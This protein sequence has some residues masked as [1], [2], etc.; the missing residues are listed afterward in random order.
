MTF[1]SFWQILDA[2]G[3]IITATAE[4]ARYLKSQW[5]QRLGASTACTPAIRAWTQAQADWLQRT[6]RRPK[7]LSAHSVIRIWQQ[8]IHTHNP[9]LT[10][11]R[12]LAKLAV[13]TDRTL[14]EHQIDPT[15]SQRLQE[16]DEC[17]I[18][19][20][21]RYQQLLDDTHSLDAARTLEFLTTQSPNLPAATVGL[22]GFT[23]EHAQ[24]T[25][26]W[27]HCRQAG[28]QLIEL[29]PVKL[30]STASVCDVATEVDE[31]TALVNWLGQALDK[32]KV[33]MIQV[34][35]EQ[36]AQHQTAL[37]RLIGE[38]LLGKTPADT[39]WARAPVR[40]SD[41]QPL[42]QSMVVADALALLELQ[43]A[44]VTPNALSRFL[45]SAYFERDAMTQRAFHQ[46]EVKLW[47]LPVLEL[48]QAQWT[49]WL[50][51][52]LPSTEPL[53]RQLREWQALRAGWQ[54]ADASVWA[55]RFLN[56][57]RAVRWP[58]G[59]LLSPTEE[60]AAQ[61]LLRQLENLAQNS[62]WLPS[63]T[64]SEA[65][66]ELKLLVQDER[67]DMGSLQAR[68]VFTS[69]YADPGLPLAGLWVA[70]LRAEHF[71][72]PVEPM[73]WIPKD[74]ARLV[75]SPGFSAEQN[76]LEAARIRTAW[77]QSASEVVYS[78]SRSDG[79]SEYT[80]VPWLT[81]GSMAALVRHTNEPTWQPMACE[82]YTETVF[83]PLPVNT[84]VFG[85]VNV[86]ETQAECPFKAALSYRLRVRGWQFPHYGI[87]PMERGNW[88]HVAL[89]KLYEKKK[90]QQ[91]LLQLSQDE[92]ASLLD[93]VLAAAT[94]TTLDVLGLTNLKAVEADWLKTQMLR[95]IATEKQRAPFTV[96][97][98]EETHETSI[99]GLKFKFKVD[100]IDAL[101]DDPSQLVLLDYKSG[102]PTNPVWDDE[103]ATSLQ[104]PIYGCFG[105][106]P[107]AQVA[108]MA[109]V[110]PGDDKPFRG[111]GETGMA[112]SKSK[113][114]KPHWPALQKYIE[115]TVSSYANGNAQAQPSESCKRCTYGMVCRVANLELEEAA[116]DADE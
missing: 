92:L 18:R 31:Q 32:H 71:P 77:A 93:T 110:Y 113:E 23:H 14:L 10:E 88:L 67:I 22:W 94:P 61:S 99:C 28:C 4:Q 11:P 83:A 87:G 81:D 35:F 21:A 102:R 20:R 75:Q 36:L 8:I 76:L 9:E 51:T 25:R 63:L 91:E 38:K 64:L 30:S 24:L 115:A 43:L 73:V 95:F 39:E 16:D 111:Y 34:Q 107:T 116:E 86:I 84:R 47:T 52:A 26:W 44:T 98:T 45:R 33:G 19:W 96:I 27:N 12:A 108:G 78:V 42:A 62:A 82:P 101:N 37:A 29:P 2:G 72:K 17:F 46:L 80:P 68:V 13:T 56:L 112:D 79:K 6:P 3:E 48:T 103:E 50:Q 90:S 114:L 1:D 60:Q 58:K 85:G 66:A 65:V 53:L 54:T 106:K 74:L 7:L 97:A 59:K 5:L 105:P 41:G 104:L 100:R 89:E 69:R 40:F 70:G 49:Q 57:L 15:R 55:E 109:L